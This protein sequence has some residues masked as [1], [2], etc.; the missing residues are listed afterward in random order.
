M[1]ETEYGVREVIVSHIRLCLKNLL[2]FLIFECLS[3]KF[4]FHT[5]KSK[6]RKLG[7]KSSEGIFVGYAFDSP[8]W[9]VYNPSTRSITRTNSDVFNEQ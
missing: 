9:L 3:V 2:I 7:K 5:D 4:F 6:Q 1:Y 8:A